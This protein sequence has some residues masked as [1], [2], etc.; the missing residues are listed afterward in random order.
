MDTDDLDFFLLD[1]V[2]QGR[3]PLHI[4]TWDRYSLSLTVNRDVPSFT[5]HELIAALLELQAAGDVRLSWKQKR[6]P[7][8]TA[9]ELEAGIVGAVPLHYGLTRRGGDRWAR[10][11]GID[12]RLWVELDES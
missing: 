10:V 4:F 7:S 8:V 6:L 2:V 1:I 3:F 11:C 9:D 5:W 12:W